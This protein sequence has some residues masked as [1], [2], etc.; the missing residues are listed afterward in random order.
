[1]KVWVTYVGT[2]G[3]LQLGRANKVKLSEQAGHSWLLSM[4]LLGR[5]AHWLA[6]TGLRGTERKLKLSSKNRI[7]YLPLATSRSI[8]SHAFL[9]FLPSTIWILDLDFLLL[10]HA[11]FRKMTSDLCW[12]TNHWWWKGNLSCCPRPPSVSPSTCCRLTPAPPSPPHPQHAG[13]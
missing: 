8:C 7:R 10:G 12:T 2:V 13:C 1:M 4:R 5:R 11:C 3:L 9:I 6:L